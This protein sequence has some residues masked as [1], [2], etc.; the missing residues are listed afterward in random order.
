MSKATRE[1]QSDALTWMNENPQSEWER[2]IRPG[3]LG[4][5]EELINALGVTE[6]A[7]FLGVQRPY[8]DG[9]LTQKAYAAFRAYARAWAATIERALRGQ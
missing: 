7:K 1:G 9:E 5:D 3:T 2:A 6:A 4:A 8:V